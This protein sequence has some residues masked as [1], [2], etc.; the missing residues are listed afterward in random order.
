[1]RQPTPTA[2]ARSRWLRRCAAFAILLVLA[3]LA[4]ADALTLGSFHHTVISTQEGAPGAGAM[5]QTPDGFLWI[6]GNKGLTRFDG[7]RFTR[8]TPVSGEAFPE[9]DL[10]QLHPAEGGGLWIATDFGVT[11]LRD[12]HLRHFGSAEGYIGTRGFFLTDA[13]GRVWSRTSLALMRFEHGAWQSIWTSP[14][15]TLGEVTLD[16]D[17]NMWALIN[18]KLNVWPK[19]GTGFAEVPGV[20]ENARHVLAGASGHLYVTAPTEVHFYRRRGTELT[21]L[22]KP[23]TARVFRLIEG[24][25][26]SL[27]LGGTRQ[28]IYFVAGED[29]TAAEAQH[30][31]PRAQ[32]MSQLEGLTSNYAPHLLEDREGDLWVNTPNG[33]DR[34]RRAAFTRIDLPL[35][36]HTISAAADKDGNVWIGSETQPL[37]LRKKTGELTETELPPLTL[38]LYADRSAEHVWAANA[39]GIWRLTPAGAQLDK[40]L[41]REDTGPIGSLPCMLSDHAGKLYVCT[42]YSGTGH[43]LLKLEDGQWKEAFNHPVFPQTIALDAKGDV[44]AGSRE[45]NRLYRLSNGTESSIGEREGLAAGVVKSI[46]PDGDGLWLGGDD[47]VQY[48]DGKH[49]TTLATDD[50]ELGRPVVGLA[51]DRHGDLWAQTLDGVLRF[52]AADIAPVKAGE[53]RQ[54]HPDVFNDEDNVAGS[55]DTTWTNP[56]LRMGP[57]GRIWAQT[58]TALAWVDPDRIPVERER[59]RVAIDYLETSRR[60]VPSPQQH[61]RL[62]P[63]EKAVRIAFTAA[64]LGRP[65]KLRFRYRLVGMSDEWTDAED[66]RDAAFTN[67]APGSYRFEVNAINGA[68]LTSERPGTI[69]FERLPAYYETWWFR[70]M[71]ALPVALILWLAHE[72]RS[73]TLA[74]RLK[75]RADEREAI[76]RDIHD[77]LLQRLHAVMLSLQRLIADATIPP[78]SRDA[79]ARIRD[80]TREAI[81]EGREQIGMLRRGQDSGLALYDELMAEGRRLREQA[82]IHF[83]LDVHGAPRPLQSA[84]AVELRDAALEAM[85]NAFAH[86]GAS[87]VQVALTYEDR[88]FWIVVTDDGHG[89]D[90]LAAKQAGHAGHYGLLGMRE[91]IARLKGSV[92]I[93]SSPEEGTEVH[94]RAPARAIYETGRKLGVAASAGSTEPRNDR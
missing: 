76:A 84:A 58:S 17:G 27:W 71:W 7:R 69:S 88:A 10:G 9:A 33:L 78:S 89:F 25:E 34:F 57:D 53:P 47:G 37:L 4:R 60:A 44:W 87:G 55:P 8:F 38:A 68:G 24:Q 36:I 72:M 93:E 20:V 45:K 54:L 22:A 30:D 23:V 40:A 82:G 91:R 6:A 59:P 12:G 81:A 48:F 29:L 79:L 16:G 56:N 85:R 65:D 18:R 35:A 32:N 14:D 75:I 21:E 73:R 61:L 51:V 80:D 86:S 13:T 83:S 90:R 63:G 28:G 5:A 31:A 3:G 50:P 41:T 19:N 77:T 2:R 64:A 66:R 62:D 92:Q 42:P 46:Y 1:M 74:R 67:L 70:A 26:H 49:C 52:R 15:R 94:L 39:Q 43:G 11:L